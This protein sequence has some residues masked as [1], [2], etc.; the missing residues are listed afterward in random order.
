MVGPA[1][2][3]YFDRFKPSRN[4]PARHHVSEGVVVDVLVVL[5]RPDHMADMPLAIRLRHSPGRP[6]TSGLQQN[7]RAGIDEEP[8]VA[9]RTPVLPDRISDV[10]GNVMLHPA[11]RD[12]D[13]LSAGP[14]HPSGRGSLAVAARFQAYSAP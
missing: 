2:A 7:L 5:V 1:G 9:R 4:V 6:E 11:G 8:V 13:G 14:H 3:H 10:G 12:V